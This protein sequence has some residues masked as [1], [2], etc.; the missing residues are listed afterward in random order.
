MLEL[1]KKKFISKLSS[2]FYQSVILEK[3]FIERVFV[4]NLWPSKNL[5]FRN[6]ISGERE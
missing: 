5:L 4:I 1:V 3:I 2:D 6:V